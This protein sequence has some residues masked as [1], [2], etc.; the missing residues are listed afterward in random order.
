[1]KVVYCVLVSVT[2]QLNVVRDPVFDAAVN[3]NEAW[4]DA[5]AFKTVFC[6]F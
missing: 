6:R 3:V 5:P 1:V 2:L 4:I